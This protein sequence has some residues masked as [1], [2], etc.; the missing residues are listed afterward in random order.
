ME[1]AGDFSF[2]SPNDDWDVLGNSVK[3]GVP[4]KQIVDEGVRADDCGVG[5]RIN[6]ES[7]TKEKYASMGEVP[8]QSSPEEFF[9]SWMLEGEDL[10]PE[11]WVAEVWDRNL[12]ASEINLVV[13]PTYS[14]AEMMAIA[15]GYQ[16][17]FPQHRMLEEKSLK[18]EAKLRH[19]EEELSASEVEINGLRS[20]L[21]EKEQL[22]NAEESLRLELAAD[23][24]ITMS[25]IPEDVCLDIFL[26]LPVKSLLTSTKEYKKIPKLQLKGYMKDYNQGVCAFGYDCKNDDYKIIYVVKFNGTNDSSLV[27]V[28]NLG[29]NSWKISRRVLDGFPSRLFIGVLVDG[30]FHW[31]NQTHDK[32][33]SLEISDEKFEELE[34]PEELLEKK[35]RSITIGVLE[36]CLALVVNFQVQFEVWVMQ[37]YGIRESWTKS[38]KIADNRIQSDVPYTRLVCSFRNGEVLVLL[39]AYK[40]IVYDTKHASTREQSMLDIAFYKNALNYF[41]SLVSLNSDSY[42]GQKKKKIKFKINPFKIFCT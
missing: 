37:E 12:R 31:L 40:L 30:N 23:P 24:P 39:A 28:Y 38:Y 3:E 6:E 25:R 19:R 5:T 13:D 33:I 34:K 4:G 29:T 15:D 21:K 35:H 7:A 17:G 32:I 11:D 22:G 42:V 26:R 36:R 18:L 20:L 27:G 9:Q 2:L 1:F 41:E 8:A 14:I 10:S 16:Y